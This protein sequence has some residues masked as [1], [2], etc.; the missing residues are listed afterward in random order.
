MNTTA[1]LQ[2]TRKPALPARG[3]HREALEALAA[4]R[5]E[6]NW[7]LEKRY[8]GW[9]HYEQAEPPFWRRTE[10]KLD[11]EELIPYAPAQ[12]PVD[13][14]TALPPKLHAALGVYGQRAGL[15][16]QRDSARVYRDLGD[17]ARRQGV[18]WTDLSTAAREHP[19]IVQ[20]RFMD[21]A[22]PVTTDKYT[23]LHAAFW[24][25][26]TLLYVPR[27]VTVE[28]PFISVL[29]QE[30]PQL[31]S[32][33]HTLLV[34]EEG[35]SVTLVSELLSMG[36]DACPD[37]YHGGVTELYVGPGARV[38]YINTQDLGRHIYDLRRQTALL[39]RDSRLEWLTV[40]LGGKLSRSSQHTVLRGSGAEAKVTGLYLPD[41][42]QH[43]A[44]DTLQDHVATSGTSDLLYQGALL[45]RS[46]AVYEGTIRAWPGAQKTNAYQSNR[47]LLLSPK[48]R[49]DSLPQLEIEAND[50]RCTHGA[51]VS[52]VDQDQV[53][54]LQ[55]RGIPRIEAVRLI[56]EGFF[57]PTLDRL[58][59]SLEGLRDR[60]TGAI[61][62]KLSR[63]A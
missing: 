46:R 54:Y 4:E 44:F 37:T 26:G 31:A 52:Q 55:S 41:G 34:A 45:G 50:L 8:E 3:F 23:A 7:L 5:N 17:E 21:E 24:S 59:E 10:L 47:N 38:R 43:V 19:E 60:L 27:G 56:V 61:A 12:R 57:Q 13:D 22:V 18:I 36:C 14:L 15:M 42:K 20:G 25:G 49:A 28:L 11:W 51:T 1:T 30:M 63:S 35:S 29:W 32:M 6:P 33:P 48:A 16:V 40:T 58:P 9:A 2:R 39:D 62:D 53:F